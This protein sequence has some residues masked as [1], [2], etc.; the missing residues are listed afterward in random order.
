MRTSEPKPEQSEP[1]ELKKMSDIG[2][3]HL[4]LFISESFGKES[5]SSP[6]ISPCTLSCI[7]TPKLQHSPFSQVRDVCKR[8]QEPAPNPTCVERQTCAPQ[9]AQSFCCSASDCESTVS[10]QTAGRPSQGALLSSTSASRSP[11]TCRDGRRW[12]PAGLLFFHD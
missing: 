5:S 6:A 12:R 11:A 4:L 9:T 1:A 3:V 7:P 8:W 10:I 2:T